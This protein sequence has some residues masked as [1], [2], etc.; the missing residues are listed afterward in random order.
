MCCSI[1]ASVCE[2]FMDV[3]IEKPL[4]IRD[5]NPGTTS[6]L[7]TNL[8]DSIPCCPVYRKWLV[9]DYWVP[10]EISLEDVSHTGLE[11]NSHFSKQ[12]P[13]PEVPPRFYQLHKM[14]L[15]HI[16]SININHVLK[17]KNKA[18]IARPH[19]NH[20]WCGKFAVG[21]RIRISS[22]LPGDAGPER[23]L[24]DH[25]HSSNTWELAGRSES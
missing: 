1:L 17:N 12:G 9:Y 18:Q 4:L 2:F 5:Q 13:G 11:A 20:L 23:Q 25:R 6:A 14:Q 21:L 15:Q 24:E 16:H 10:P 19:D 3:V 8:Q 7:V 22:K